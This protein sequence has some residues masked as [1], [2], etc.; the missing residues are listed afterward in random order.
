M[1]CSPNLCCYLL[2]GQKDVQGSE[3]SQ[4]CSNGGERKESHT[5]KGLD[6]RGCHI[7]LKIPNNRKSSQGKC[8]SRTPEARCDRESKGRCEKKVSWK[9]HPHLL[10][11]QQPWLES[12]AFRQLVTSSAPRH[13]RRTLLQVPVLVAVGT[14]GLGVLA[15]TRQL[16]AVEENHLPRHRFELLRPLLVQ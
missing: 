15:C 1:P 8:K 4:G 7:L 10:A 3:N 12:A 2:Q 11:S 6:E 13:C 14:R 16:E 5:T 9:L